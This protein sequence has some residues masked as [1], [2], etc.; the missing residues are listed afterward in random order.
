MT[1]GFNPHEGLIVVKAVIEGPSG[2]AVVRLALD[3]GATGTLINIGI[4]AALGYDPSLTSERVQVTT[5]SSVEFVPQLVLDRIEALKRGRSEFPVLCHS[6]PPSAGID[7]IL[8][9]D[10]FRESRLFIDFQEGYI[11]LQP[12]LDSV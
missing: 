4:L 11:D 10:F 3:T 1:T 9:L 2:S 7:G 5:G 8:G 6:L 12:P